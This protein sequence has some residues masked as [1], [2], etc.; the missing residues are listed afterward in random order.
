MKSLWTKISQN[1]ITVNHQFSEQEKK[2]LVFF[3]QVLFIGLIATL[4]QIPSVWPFLGLKSLSFLVVCL[5]LFI[6]LLLNNKGNFKR[7]KEVY[8]IF[9]FAFGTYT[10]TLIGGAA[11]YH[12]QSMLIF[13]SCLIILDYKKER[14]LILAGLPFMILSIL[15]GEF[16]WF[17]APDYSDHP[18]TEAL[19]VSN[20]FS[21]VVIITIFIFFIIRLNKSSEEALAK[22][23]KEVTEDAEKLESIVQERT[24]ELSKQRDV[25]KL[26]NEEK[27]VLLKEVHHRV[28][29]NLQIIVSLIN[30]QLEAINNDKT[31]LALREIQSRVS[32]MSLVHQKMYQSSSFKDIR[33]TEYSEQIISNLGD[34]YGVETINYSV[35]IPDS[36][37]LEMD[38]A[39]PVGLILN[40]IISNFFKHVDQQK[41]YSFKLRAHLNDSTFELVYIDNGP[42][43]P[44]GMDIA[45]LQS[46]GLQLISN[47][48]EQLEGNCKIEN[49][50]GA[51]YTIQIPLFKQD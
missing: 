22:I 35:E 50:E 27:I 11:L 6:C 23:L 17:E 12:V 5:I 26:K 2:R 48:C 16:G 45:K 10:T 43:F 33:L 39:I 19:R 40:E 41:E 21:I 18:L 30:L 36:F 44:E 28:R 49:N 14:H 24:H 31:T 46:L 37:T 25:L 9:V 15:I 51:C 42:G 8:V 34:L 20:I 47:L 4:L 38:Q 1:G 3:N 29:N 7:S 32:S 13:F